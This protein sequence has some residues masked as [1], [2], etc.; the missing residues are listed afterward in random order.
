MTAAEPPFIGKRSRPFGDHP[1]GYLSYSADGRMYAIGVAEDHP[2]PRDLVPTDDEKVK[3]QERMFAY[4]GKYEADGEKVVHH[5]DISW[6]QS[7]TGTDQ[8]RFYKLNGNT[9]TITTARG[10]SAFDGEE[11]EFVLVWQKVQ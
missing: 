11:G 8:V 5:V 10:Q 6:N 4:A 7:W 2:K 9:L 1:D 3:L